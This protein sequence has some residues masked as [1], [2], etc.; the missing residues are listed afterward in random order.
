MAIVN[1][2]VINIGVHYLFKLEVL[3]FSRYVPWSAIARSCGSSIFSI[4][5]KFC[6]VFHSGCTSVHS[7]QQGRRFSFSAQPLQHLLF[8]DFLMMA[9]L[10][11]VKVVP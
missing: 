5:R 8:V 11:S 9:I 1:S 3:S 10:T 4:L 6:A 7:H 2:A